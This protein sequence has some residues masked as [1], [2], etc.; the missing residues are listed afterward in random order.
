[1][2]DDDG[3]EQM[4][5]QDILYCFI[6]IE[7]DRFRLDPSNSTFHYHRR[8]TPIT[9]RCLCCTGADL[10]EAFS[11][12]D[13]AVSIQQI[14]LTTLDNVVVE[15]ILG[16]LN[17]AWRVSRFCEA[18][19]SSQSLVVM[20]FV[21]VIRTD[22]LEHISLFS[23]KLHALLL[24]KQLSLSKLLLYSD[25]HV[26]KLL[27]IAC[28][29]LDV[30]NEQKIKR[31]ELVSTAGESIVSTVALLDTLYSKKV[32]NFVDAV[33]DEQA[34]AFF[35]HV[36]REA[37]QTYIKNISVPWMT[38]GTLTND[39]FQEFFVRQCASNATGVP[40]SS[41]V[42]DST[43][44]MKS[45]DSCSTE[46]YELCEADLIPKFLRRQGLEAGMYESGLY[47][48]LANR[49]RAVSRF[50]NADLSLPLHEMVGRC[51]ASSNKLLLDTICEGDANTL[52]STLRRLCHQHFFLGAPR[53]VL[54]RFMEHFGDELL[55]CD[56]LKLRQNEEQ[57]NR[58]FREFMRPLVDDEYTIECEV[59]RSDD[60]IE[61]EESAM[62]V[63]LVHASS[64]VP[65]AYE[66]VVTPES[67]HIYQTLSTSLL[68]LHFVKER[69]VDIAYKSFT[70]FSA[71]FLHSVYA[72]DFCLVLFNMQTFITRFKQFFYDTVV[73]T[74]FGSLVAKANAMISS[75]VIDIK[76]LQ[77]MHSAFVRQCAS[78]STLGDAKCRE[79]LVLL[80]RTVMEYCQLLLTIRR[81]YTDAAMVDDDK[82]VPN[83]QAF[84]EILAQY[85]KDHDTLHQQFNSLFDGWINHAVVETTGKDNRFITSFASHR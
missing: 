37:T 39:V 24:K 75:G 61:G 15:K 55:C 32:L 70:L 30:F 64:R 74:E 54:S 67:L 33:H 83:E 51:T 3:E 31:S 23:A 47:V 8:G 16:T 69:F 73:S 38:R 68:L 29:L 50:I 21:S 42:D 58:Q 12:I 53:D 44:S 57:E 19:N 59:K 49:G 41:S 48:N 9:G 11:G 52:V 45:V 79:Y 7:S 76:A 46:M 13:K 25:L 85:V 65:K 6:G 62:L 4:L 82:S 80:L 72:K 27:V 77:E 26:S 66:V 36:R 14:A 71:R 22:V 60:S 40:A 10:D 20:S 17:S 34:A 28:M 1:M 43:S 56:E 78:G 5:L 81:E 63:E 2:S 18:E 84:D 35:D